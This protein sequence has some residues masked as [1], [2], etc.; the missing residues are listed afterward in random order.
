MSSTA[1]IG[2]TGLTQIDGLEI[3][4]REMARSP[5]GAPSGPVIYG[6]LNG[7]E[8]IFLA[9]HGHGHTIPPHRINYRANM[10]ALKEAG[11]DRVIA[12]ASV[13]GI[14]EKCVPR[15]VVIPDQIID[16]T[17]GREHTYFDGTPERVEHVGFSDPYDEAV[18]QQLIAAAQTADVPLVEQGCYGVTQGPRYETAAEVARMRRDGCTIVG[19]TGMPEAALAR[20]LGLAYASCS[21]VVAWAA[22]RSPQNEGADLG[23]DVQA[24]IAS[25]GV[26]VQQL[27]KAS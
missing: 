8:V 3:T 13:G 27:V 9:R 21:V 24:G 16:Y 10:W 26:V 5:Y 11:A 14:A 17:H 7:K 2:G 22:G 15:S 19:M 25:V 18:R 6:E 20:E 12:V 23:A 4:R 1:I